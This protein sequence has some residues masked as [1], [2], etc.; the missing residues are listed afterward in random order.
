M[1]AESKNVELCFEGYSRDLGRFGYRFRVSCINTG[2]NSESDLM[3]FFLIK[4]LS[5]LVFDMCGG[6]LESG[7]FHDEAIMEGLYKTFQVQESWAA[8]RRMTPKDVGA[9]LQGLDTAERI[10]L[11]LALSRFHI[12]LVRS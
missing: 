5:A 9:W 3:N 7:N 11:L 2:Y 4:K 8:V 12:D 10:L 1:G 6:V